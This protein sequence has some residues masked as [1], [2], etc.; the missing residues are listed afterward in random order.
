MLIM[1]TN[2]DLIMSMQ[3][4]VNSKFDTRDLGQSNVII[5]IQIIKNNER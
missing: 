3:K 2:K 4:F 5:R 1:E